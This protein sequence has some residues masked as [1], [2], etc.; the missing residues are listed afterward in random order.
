MKHDSTKDFDRNDKATKDKYVW[1]HPI[2]QQVLHIRD[3]RFK[4]LQSSASKYIVG[5]HK[6]LDYKIKE[7][8]CA[9]K[10]YAAEII[11]MT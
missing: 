2:S 4:E 11:V 6:T 10:G 8:F 7:H 5:Q 9:F 1:V 3:M